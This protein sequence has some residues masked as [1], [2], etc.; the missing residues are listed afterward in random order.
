VV[1]RLFHWAFALVFLGLLGGLALQHPD[2]RGIPFMGS[3]LVREVH[4]TLALL[5]LCL[6]ALAAAWD[7]FRSVRVLLRDVLGWRAH[8]TRWLA[9]LLGRVVR[10]CDALPAQGRFNAGQ[11]LN[12]RATIGLTACLALTG[13]LITPHPSPVPQAW[14]ELLY[15]LHVALA[16]LAIPLV[17]GHVLLATLWPSTRPS[18]WGMLRG[19]VSAEWARQHHRLWAERD[20][21]VAESSSAEL[22]SRSS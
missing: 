22:P 6:P 17:L 9:A 13:V 1:E 19:R 21:Q 16:Y 10:R 12:A 18:L 5:L 15:Q 4:L 14:R 2:L 11:K 8:D 3:K 7:D 20:A